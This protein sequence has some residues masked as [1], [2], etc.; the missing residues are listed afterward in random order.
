VIGIVTLPLEWKMKDDPR[1]Q[2]YSSYLMQAYSNFVESAGAR[3][4]PIIHK[5]PKEVTL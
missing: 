3:V 1:Y 4:V 5:E 2:G